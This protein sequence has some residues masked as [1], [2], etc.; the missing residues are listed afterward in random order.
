MK[1]LDTREREKN[2]LHLVVESYIVE[3]KPISSGYLY[4]KFSLSCSTATIRSVMESLE[5]KGLLSHVYTSS[6]RVP[7]QEGFQCYVANLKEE[8]RFEEDT[9][10]VHSEVFFSVE[11]DV[12][13][14]ESFNRA[15]DT[16]SEISGYISLVA[17]EGKFIFK[18]TRFIFDYPEFEDVRK[19]K[20][21]FY[22]LE[23]KIQELQD[24]LSNYFTGGVGIL[25][26]D[27]IGFKEISD[28]SLVI[29]GLNLRDLS[30]SL[31]LLGPMRMDYVKAVSS[32]CRVR[33]QLEETV[34][35]ML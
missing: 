5:K 35:R 6:G 19:L 29:A 3:S 34:G 24:L 11:I 30:G 18:G 17:F 28:C 33:R 14:E 9:N 32:I 31:A 12:S 2:I 1:C 7:T 8:E 21:V 16:L 25:I 4:K 20:S 26:G 10:S 13:I 27:E 22:T 23:V 15:L